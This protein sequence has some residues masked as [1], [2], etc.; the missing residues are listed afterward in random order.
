M[1]RAKHCESEGQASFG[2][3]SER[4]TSELSHE[5][6]LRRAIQLLPQKHEEHLS[7]KK[8]SAN[9][10]ECLLEVENLRVEQA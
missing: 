10:Y 7:D 4:A 6:S 1:L 8:V 3:R 5:S 2:C 9:M